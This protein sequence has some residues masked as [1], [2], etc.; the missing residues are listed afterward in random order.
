MTLTG[1]GVA[2]DVLVDWL[3][4]RIEIAEAKEEF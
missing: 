1:G 3:T 4:G 2:Y